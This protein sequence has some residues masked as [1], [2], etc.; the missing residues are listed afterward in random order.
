MTAGTGRARAG[1]VCD[2]TVPALLVLGIAAVALSVAAAV[3]TVAVQATSGAG[4]ALVVVV[5]TVTA[6][7][8]LLTCAVTTLAAVVLDRA[9]RHAPRVVRLL[10][11]AAVPVGGLVLAATTAGDAPV[12]D[13]SVP[14][15]VVGALLCVHWAVLQVR[16]RRRSSDVDHDGGAATTGGAPPGLRGGAD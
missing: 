8:V 5:A 6:G 3:F 9:T 11:P 12:G 1:S 10:A 2:H 7:L 4:T 14:L 16:T 15:L 13:A